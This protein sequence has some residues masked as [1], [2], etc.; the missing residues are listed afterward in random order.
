MHGDCCVKVDTIPANEIRARLRT[1]IE[2]DV[3]REK[4]NVLETIE[5]DEREQA[6]EAL[7]DLG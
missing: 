2:S 7:E 5:S 1:T 6:R 3:E 4:W